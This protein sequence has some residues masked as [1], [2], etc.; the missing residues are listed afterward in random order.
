MKCKK[1]GDPIL[2]AVCFDDSVQL[3]DR[4]QRGYLKLHR[5]GSYGE[6][7]SKYMIRKYGLEPN[8]YG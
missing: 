7:L 8:A 2:L 6:C 1:C 5:C 3:F 4:P